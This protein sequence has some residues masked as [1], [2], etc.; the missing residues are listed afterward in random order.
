MADRA[1]TPT[2]LIVAALIQSGEFKIADEDREK[3]RALKEDDNWRTIPALVDLRKLADGIC[4]AATESL[5]AP[6]PGIL[7]QITGV[8]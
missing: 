8:G 3:I 2:V 4:R 1:V 7:N 6:D 5:D